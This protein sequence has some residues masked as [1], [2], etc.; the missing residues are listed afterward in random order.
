MKWVFLLWI[1]FF[2][3]CSTNISSEYITPPA[4]SDQLYLTAKILDPEFY[5]QAFQVSE[6]RWDTQIVPK[7]RILVVNHH[8]LAPHLIADTLKTVDSQSIKNIII[9]SPNH[10]S[11][12]SQDILWGNF[13]WKTPFGILESIQDTPESEEVFSD[14]AKIF[15]NEHGVSGIVGFLK[16]A[17]PQA[18]ISSVLQ[19][20]S[21]PIEK[22]TALAKD[23][24]NTFK[25]ED[26]LI[27]LSID[28]SH[29][30]F[31]QI[32]KFHD[33]T[34]IEAFKKWDTQN[35]HRLDVDSI[36]SIRTVFYLAELWDMMDFQLLHHTNSSEITQNPYQPDT[37]S[38]ITGYFQPFPFRDDCAFIESTKSC[39]QSSRNTQKA[40]TLFLGDMMLDRYIRQALDAHGWEY[41]LDWRMKRF[42]RG[43][44]RTLVNFEGAMTT[45]SPYPAH[46]MMLSFTSDPKWAEK[47]AEYGINIAGLANNHSLNFGAEGLLQ[48]HTFLQQEKIDTFGEPFNT[49]NL[50]TIQNI[51]GIKIG[52]IGYHELFD[53]NTAPVIAEIQHLRDQV[54][55][56]VVYAHWGDEYRSVIHPRPQK[57]ARQFIDMG[58]DMVIGHHPH[59]VQPMEQYN[60]KYIFYS[61]GNFVFDQADY[62]SVRTR[63]GLGV[64]FECRNE[65]T[66]KNISYTL[67]PLVSNLKHQVRLMN[68]EEQEVFF[69]WFERIS[70]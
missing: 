3:A 67:F 44:D 7:T 22:S 58:A 26:T 64:V 68:Q 15:Q 4:S 32:S 1:F 37:T 49:Q 5:E 38:Y 2:S 63:L 59:V 19:K 30:L 40:T 34:T 33:I 17:F 24:F 48:T 11:R 52:F 66:Q 60:G 39:L 57:K 20:D 46:D 42:M 16:Y 9:L 45:F 47:M 56:I 14:S 65:C 43:T 29:D 10:F 25:A 50:S 21:T 61:L 27:I 35:F 28:V 18:H 36:P 6:K 69:Q 55:F 13:S 41:L 31:P 70:H 51:R 23:I 12:G 62:A 8:L 53:G 54:D